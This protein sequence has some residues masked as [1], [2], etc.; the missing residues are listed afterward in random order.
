MNATAFIIIIFEIYIL[1]LLE[2]YLPYF[3]APNTNNI[4]L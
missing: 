4:Y 3:A 1:L 2:M